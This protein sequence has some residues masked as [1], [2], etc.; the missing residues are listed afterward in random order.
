MNDRPGCLSGLL[1]LFLLDALFD[2]L[3]SRFGFGRGCS[4]SGCGCGVILFI[5]F[6]IFA[7]SILFSTNWTNLGF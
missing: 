6:I 3:Q 2:W 7:C 4:C 5:L 1:K